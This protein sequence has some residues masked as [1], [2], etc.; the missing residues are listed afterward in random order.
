VRNAAAGITQLRKKIREQL[1]LIV[2]S[3]PVAHFAFVDPE[4]KAAIRIG[5]YPG[6]EY[7]GST[8]LPV[9]R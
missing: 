3:F 8:I 2:Y 4:G 1:V 5:A 9:V 6:F 7:Y